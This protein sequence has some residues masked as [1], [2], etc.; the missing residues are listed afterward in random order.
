MKLFDSLSRKAEEFVPVEGKNVAMYVCG[1]TP[2]DSTH[3]GHA[4]TYVAF[5]MIKRFLTKKGYS[6]YHIQNITDVEDK[7][8]NRCRE[9]GADPKALTTHTHDEAMELFQKLG[10]IPADAYPTVTGHIP[11]IISLIRL[12]IEKDAAYETKTGVYFKVSSF[13]G[14]GKLSGQD[15]EQI[16]AGARVEIDESKSD[17]ADFALWKKTEGDLIEFDSPWGRGRPGWHIEC[18]A[19]AREYAKRT[20]DIH[21]G[22][23]D[24]IFPHHENEIAQSEAALGYRFCNHW[25]HTGFLTVHG[26]KMS[27][28]LGNFVTLRQALSRYSPNGMR[29]FFLQ[30]HYRSPLDYD[31]D[32]LDAAEESVERIFN[33][34]GLIR[35][36]EAGGKDDPDADFRK[37]SD[38]LIKAF[39]ISMEDDFNT[40]EAIASLFTLL[41]LANA[42]ISKSPDR[43]QLAIIRKGLDEMLWILGLTEQR[44]N[45]EDKSAALSD[46]LEELGGGAASSAAEAL[47]RLI[48][49]RDESRAKKDYKKSDVIRTKLKE[50]GIVL[51]DKAGAGG[52]RWK[53]A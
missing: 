27:K 32:A 5:D 30:M 28:S 51:E 23:R 25:L 46:L 21:G 3:I 10:I 41:R 24:L 53:F 37:K 36:A 19:L 26:E 39:H 6:V 50:V 43:R 15:F 12:L 47:E 11:Q 22:A 31:E 16:R 9:T 14:Y 13:K 2:Y 4:R 17:P 45:L 52:V 8:I 35:E 29:L 49:L 34:L 48:K 42:N 38:E 18:S 44:E 33:S 7:I 40:P 20:L 1:I